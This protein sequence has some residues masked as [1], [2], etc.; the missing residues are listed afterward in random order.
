MRKEVC[1]FQLIGGLGNQLFI[2]MAA[3]Q[4]LRDGYPTKINTF[5][6]GS[7]G[8]SHG[9]SIEGIVFPFKTPEFKETETDLS[10]FKFRLISLL[11]RKANFK[12]IAN[13][14]IENEHG[15]SDSSHAKNLEGRKHLGYFQS[16]KMFDSSLKPL[17]F[18]ITPKI[19]SDKFIHYS[20]EA[21]ETKP[22]FLHIRRGDY[23]TYKDTFGVLSMDYY[24]KAL[25]VLRQEGLPLN[26]LW[27]ISSDEA[28]G[29]ELG[30]KL[31]VNFRVISADSKLSDIETLILM[32]YGSAH[33]IAN[34]TYSWW[35]A[36]ISK[37]TKRVVA[38]SP[39]F[40]NAIIPKSLIPEN[41]VE[42][43][44]LWI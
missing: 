38:P 21:E 28:I 13:W 24:E 4:H 44:S 17:L 31:G 29:S 8:D 20:R 16:P 19:P 10:A 7:Y 33:I 9:S 40:K 11:R 6:L 23:L 37:N 14:Q 43:E 5:N 15:F 32:K 27:I 3:T 41:W 18:D 30:M 1:E 2:M 25:N 35:G 22:I 42:I 39:W 36:F 12:N 34:S 26:E